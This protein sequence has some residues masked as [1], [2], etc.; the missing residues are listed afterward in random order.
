MNDDRAALCLVVIRLGFI[1]KF[2]DEKLR[3]QCQ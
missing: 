3:I 2:D 1:L